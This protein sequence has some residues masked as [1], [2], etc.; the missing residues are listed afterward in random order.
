[1]VAHSFEKSPVFA[2]GEGCG[3]HRILLTCIKYDLSIYTRTHTHTDSKNCDNTTGAC[4]ILRTS[5]TVRRRCRGK[6]F[7][8]RFLV[9]SRYLYYYI[10]NFS[11]AFYASCNFIFLHI[12]EISTAATMFKFSLSRCKNLSYLSNKIAN[13][14][15]PSFKAHRSILQI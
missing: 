13:E 5:V 4:E 1:M 10:H 3:V 14:A 15:I 11:L 6:L 7:Y 2:T 12:E 8:V 9:N